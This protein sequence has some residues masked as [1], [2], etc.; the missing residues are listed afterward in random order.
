MGK[1]NRLREAGSEARGTRCLGRWA[2][3]S[4]KCL[5]AR[6]YCQES[7]LSLP[8]Q[9]TSLNFVNLKE[10][11][12]GHNGIMYSFI[13]FTRGKGQ[14]EEICEPPIPGNERS[15]TG[16]LRNN[17][18]VEKAMTHNPPVKH[19]SLGFAKRKLDFRIDF[20]IF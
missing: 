12:L 13:S 20:L 6:V 19:T 9:G 18:T 4:G 10:I 8:S 14:M 3:G 11:N 17:P 5:E 15:S 2:G 1:G 7:L 16:F